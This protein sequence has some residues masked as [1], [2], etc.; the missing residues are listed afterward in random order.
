MESG[1][2]RPQKDTKNGIKLIQLVLSFRCRVGS[3]FP[4]VECLKGFQP[5]PSRR[6]IISQ[7]S[8]SRSPVRAIDIDAD[9]R[10]S[11]QVVKLDS[12]S[13]CLW[14]IK[15]WEKDK[16][17]CFGSE[18]FVEEDKVPE[19][20]KAAL[21][22]NSFVTKDHGF[23]LLCCLSPPPVTFAGLCCWPMLLSPLHWEPGA[24]RSFN[25]PLQRKHQPKSYLSRQ[26]QALAQWRTAC[27]CFLKSSVNDC[28][29]MERF[30]QMLYRFACS[31]LGL[32]T[33]KKIL[34]SCLRKFGRAANLGNSDTEQFFGTTCHTLTL[35]LIYHVTSAHR[36]P[37]RRSRKEAQ[38]QQ[39]CRQNRTCDEMMWHV[40]IFWHILTY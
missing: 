22:V 31:N 33:L 34:R 38:R 36:I 4:H 40:M 25:H 1:Y 21:K 18:W 14:I 6:R 17:R 15:E 32:H 16:R 12:S 10:G 35:L 29:L 26:P 5:W 39:K 24:L 13:M 30:D 27:D 37:A 20:S 19:S 28:H 2:F 8:G 7:R 3:E 11:A 9:W 23:T